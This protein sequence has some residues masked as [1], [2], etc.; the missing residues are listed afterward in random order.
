MKAS[1]AVLLTLGKFIRLVLI[2]IQF[3]IL[4]VLH[5]YFVILASFVIQVA[6]TYCPGQVSNSCE[7]GEKMRS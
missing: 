2:D 5:I 4:Y 1:S 6:Y 3:G 7:K